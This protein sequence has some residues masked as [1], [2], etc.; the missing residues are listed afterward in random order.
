MS[1]SSVPCK[2]PFRFA[3]EDIR[4]S[5]VHD[6]RSSTIT[7]QEAILSLPQA[8]NA[9]RNVFAD[10][11]SHPAHFASAAIRVLWKEFVNQNYSLGAPPRRDSIRKAVVL[12]HFRSRVKGE[13]CPFIHTVAAS[14]CR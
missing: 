5:M 10:E 13:L 12:V 9:L 11:L 6:G 7:R 1:M 4:P 8:P 14:S 3:I 2:S